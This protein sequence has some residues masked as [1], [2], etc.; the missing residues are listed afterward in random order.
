[1]PRLLA[2]PRVAAVTLTGGERADSQVAGEAGRQ[3]DGSIER[4]SATE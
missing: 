3:I 1:M 4:L 2:D